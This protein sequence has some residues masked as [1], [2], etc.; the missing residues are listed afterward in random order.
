MA[1]LKA[2]GR[3]ELVRMVADLVEEPDSSF[4][5]GKHYAALMTDGNV[6]V[7]QTARWKDSGQLHDWGWKVKGKIKVGLSP[8]DF[9]RIYERKGYVVQDQSVLREM[10]TPLRTEESKPR[11][12]KAPSS[13]R[14]PTR[15]QRPVSSYYEPRGIIMVKGKRDLTEVPSEGPGL[16]ITYRS[17]SESF[18][19]DVAYGPFEDLDLAEEAAWV[20]LRENERTNRYQPPIKIIETDSLD[21]AMEDRG[22]AWWV[23]GVRK[24]PPIDP[25]QAG[26]TF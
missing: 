21:G 17:H 7:R 22:H 18:P 10:N 23:N 11:K 6:L 9:I 8:Q 16:Y 24:G 19:N 25:R 4:T 2:R 14:K 26:F 1:K 13:S 12:P 20:V 5:E 15:V 3:R